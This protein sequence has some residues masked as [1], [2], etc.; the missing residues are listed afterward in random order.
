MHRAGLRGLGYVEGRNLQI[1]SRFADADNERLPALA[2]ELVGLNVDVIV[3]WATGVVA[4]RRA[5]ATI[6][7]VMATF[8]DSV[9]AG[10]AA[11]LARPGG[12][13]TGSNFFQ[14][15]LM[16]KR[17]ELL[18]EINPT[19]TRAGVLLLRDNPANAY[20]LA[21]MGVTAKALKVFLSFAWAIRCGPPDSFWPG[22]QHH[23]SRRAP[24]VAV[25][26]NPDIINVN[27][28]LSKET[29]RQSFLHRAVNRA[30]V[31]CQ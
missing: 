28:N 11:S 14:V 1:G 23:R 3:T 20:V 18:K 25:A 19:M 16:A 6:P 22:K 13:V 17:V 12:N 8:G 7:I 5:T 21:A 29:A 26:R 10:F 2:A 9:A 24:R 30:T 27:S 4:A 31:S 15:E